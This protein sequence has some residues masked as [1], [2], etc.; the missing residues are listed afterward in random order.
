MV[1]AEVV[2]WY[3]LVEHR[4]GWVDGEGLVMWWMV[5]AWL[6][7][8]WRVMVEAEIVGWYSLVEYKV[9][10]WESITI[11]AS[12]KDY[13]ISLVQFITHK[14]KYNHKIPSLQLPIP[15]TRLFE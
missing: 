3:G 4:V 10:S 6:C 7:G 15:R 12:N 11:L 14:T 9:G 1:E 13:L 8:G 2:R 5:E